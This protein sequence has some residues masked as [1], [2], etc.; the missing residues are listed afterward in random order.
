MNMDISSNYSLQS[1]SFPS[2]PRPHTLDEWKDAL[3][4]VKQL[5]V[6]RQYKQCQLRSMELLAAAKEPVEPVRAF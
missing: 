4:G 3:N 2:T 6:Q 1:I 5:Y